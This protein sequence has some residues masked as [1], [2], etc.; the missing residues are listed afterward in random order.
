M[1]DRAIVDRITAAIRAE[2]DADEERHAAQ[3]AR[4]DLTP[5]LPSELTGG[6]QIEQVW[7]PLRGS[8][9]DWVRWSGEQTWP[10]ARRNACQFACCGGAR[11]CRV[12]G[13][14]GSVWASWDREGRHLLL[15]V[16]EAQWE[17]DR[18]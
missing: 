11:R 15:H 9:E 10:D 13:P 7:L 2:N 5:L 14:D 4:V 1:G 16:P 12:F 6:W 3:L 18:A 8:S 17:A